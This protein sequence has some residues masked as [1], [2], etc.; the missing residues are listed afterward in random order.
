MTKKLTVPKE[1]YVTA[2]M[3]RE[4]EFDSVKR[5]WVY[6]EEYAFAFLHP[7]EPNK[8]SDTTRKETQLGWAYGAYKFVDD[9]LVKLHSQYDYASKIRTY[10]EEPAKYQ[11]RVLS[12]EPLTGF[13][14]FEVATR[15]S[16]SNKVFK[17]KDPRGFV[18][19][20]TAKSLLGIILDGTIKNGVIQDACVWQANKNL[21]VYKESL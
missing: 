7:H 18:T 12:N 17:V 1:I 6:G 14:I 9:I 15:Y 2:K 11:P 5:E 13:E 4:S 16:T 21:I 10:T 19:E 3:H 8:K 20:I